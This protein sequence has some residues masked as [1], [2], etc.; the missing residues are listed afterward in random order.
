MRKSVTFN[1]LLA[2]PPLRKVTFCHT[3]VN[4]PFLV[5][6]IFEGVAASEGSGMLWGCS[7][8]VSTAW[9]SENS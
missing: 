4:S 6:G 7:L 2:K 5:L 8:S 9:V 3:Q 1:M